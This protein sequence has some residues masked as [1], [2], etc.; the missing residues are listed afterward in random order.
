MDVKLRVHW[1]DSSGG[2]EYILGGMQK[3]V[4]TSF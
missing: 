4:S 3:G 2:G 1:G